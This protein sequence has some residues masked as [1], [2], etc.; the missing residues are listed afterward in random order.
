MKSFS[1]IA[2]DKSGT[3][4]QDGYENGIRYLIV[5]GPVSLCAYV[6]VPLSHPLAGKSYDDI[7]L[8][9]HGGLTYAGAGEGTYRP[10]GY[11]WYGWDYSHAGDKSFYDLEYQPRSQSTEWTIEQ[12]KSE[13]WDATY[14]FAKLVKLAESILQHER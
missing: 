14:D 11:F 6:G 5:R 7:P 3:I 8:S 13:I 10:A 12:V 1:E 4:Y 9:V 2:A